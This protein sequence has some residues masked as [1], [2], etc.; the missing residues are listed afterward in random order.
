MRKSATTNS[1]S[2]YFVIKAIIFLGVII[3][4]TPPSVEATRALSLA[5]QSIEP[6]G[7]SKEEIARFAKSTVKLNVKAPL[8]FVWD[9]L[10]DYPSYPKI[11]KRIKSVTV[12]AREGNI[13]HIETNLKPDV[14][15]KNPIQHTVND[16]S[17]KPYDLK[18]ELL[19]GNFKHI[20]GE[21]SL[22]PL[23]ET[24]TEV[25][26]TLSV[27]P[28][29]VIPAQLCSFLIHFFQNE[30]AESFKRYVEMTYVNLQKQSM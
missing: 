12:T 21:W 16:L 26:Y 30:I 10:V 20:I 4:S 7:L 5:N 28:G 6:S 11:F 1:S 14:F 15:V 29:P 27:D 8:I 25:V 18:W 13:V 3:L 22:K 2:K 23:S 19:D 9:T 24:S 17:G